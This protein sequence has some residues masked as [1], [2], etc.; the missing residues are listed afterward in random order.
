[1]AKYVEYFK[2]P[3]KNTTAKSIRLVEQPDGGGTLEFDIGQEKVLV[4]AKELHEWLKKHY[5]R[6]EHLD[7]RLDNSRHYICASSLY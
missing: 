4:N 2:V 7:G 1:M 3:L 6:N 5:D